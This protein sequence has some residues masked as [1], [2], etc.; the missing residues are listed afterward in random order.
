MSEE[1]KSG[2][3]LGTLSIEE[4]FQRIEA[5]VG[6]MDDSSLPLEKA[7]SDYAV[8]MKLVKEAGERIDHVEKQIRVL[9]GDDE[10]A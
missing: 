7:F 8:G 1:K 2:E 6:E 10:E 5:I 4:M 3:D 9:A